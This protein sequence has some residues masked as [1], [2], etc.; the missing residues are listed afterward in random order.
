MLYKTHVRI[1]LDSIRLNLQH[2]R[3]FI[4]PGPRLLFSVKANGYG[5][6]AA[7]VSALAEREGLVDWLGLATVPEGLELRREG[8][9][10][11]IL[12]FSPAFPDEM[13]AAIDAGITLPVCEPSNIQALQA[14]CAARRTHARVHL[15]VETGMG[16]MGIAPAEAPG[17]AQLIARHCPNLFL[18]GVF[19]H[20]RYP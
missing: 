9:K 15:K 8:I 1:H 19:T 2:L 16:R 20:L 12:K 4:G 3:E 11:P 17:L 18:E 6:G 14:A 13:P 10:L 5:H 7:A